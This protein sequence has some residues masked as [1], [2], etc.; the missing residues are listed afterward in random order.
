MGKGSGVAMSCGVGY[1]RGSDPAW[2]W[3]WR[4]PLATALI[5]PLAWEPLNAVGT[6]LKRQKI[7]IK[8]KGSDSTKELL[9]HP[10][11]WNAGARPGVVA[12]TFLQELHTEKVGA[13]RSLSL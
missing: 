6:A 8:I 4:R 13:G 1:R 10:P 2:L 11:S 12:A 3:V 9:C 5:G 7:K